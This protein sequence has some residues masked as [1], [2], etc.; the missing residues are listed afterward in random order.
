MINLLPP[1]EKSKILI[2]AKIKVVAILW[3]LILF[4]IF[5]LLVFLIFINLY[6]KI[7][8]N[9]QRAKADQI[10]EFSF[11]AEAFDLEKKIAL[12]DSD[13]VEIN[14][15]YENRVYFS[16]IFNKIS[17]VMPGNIYFTN[18]TAD[19]KKG[20]VEVSISGFSPSRETLLELKKNI[21]KESDY[22]KNVY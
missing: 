8:L 21:D 12:L 6:I 19:K 10:M 11:K 9:A 1:E 17:A 7:Q 14:K 4:F 2:N 16:E 22:F 20:G 18:L 13:V 15:F 3:F 5:C